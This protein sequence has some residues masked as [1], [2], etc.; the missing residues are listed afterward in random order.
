[1]NAIRRAQESLKVLKK[2]DKEIDVDH[3]VNDRFIRQAAKELGYDYDARLA[4]RSALPFSGN[5][6]DTGTPVNDPTLA[7]Q[8][9]VKGEPKVRL[10]STVQA[11]FAALKKLQ[12]EAK[13]IRVTFV[14]DRLSGNKLFADKVWYVASGA[15]AVCVLAQERRRGL[16]RQAR[17]QPSQLHDGAARRCS[18]W[19]APSRARVASPASAA[20]LSAEETALSRATRQSR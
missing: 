17:R 7:G 13:T 18:E 1:M 4:D 11:T 6:L 9:W 20:R 16:G 14:H 12:A 2:V 8:I 3:F 15:H 19:P 10:Y 5:A